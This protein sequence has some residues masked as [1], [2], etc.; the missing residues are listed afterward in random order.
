LGALL[1]D[2]V[3]TEEEPEPIPDRRWGR[4]GGWRGWE[5]RALLLVADQ[6]TADETSRR[7]TSRRLA[8]AIAEAVPTRDR[9]GGP[10]EI[11]P[12]HPDQLER[13]RPLDE[14]TNRP[15]A[16]GAG[17]ILLA[18]GGVLLALALIKPPAD[19]RPRAA[20][21]GPDAAGDVRVAAPAPGSVLEADGKRY[22]VGQQ[23]DHLLVGDW[24]CDG[25]PTPAAFRPS[26]REVFVFDRWARTGEIAVHAIATVPEGVAM[27]SQASS[28]GCP[29]LSVR[30]AGG[31][32]VSVDLGA[33]R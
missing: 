33:L 19:Q 20:T 7:P 2:L 18:V 26:T 1:A 16:R 21:G 29:D 13:P 10:D 31:S 17:V 24:S 4:R 3:G 9:A 32:L 25:S 8:A 14:P 28:M 27:Q 11:E 15:R 22:L 6:A 12:R 5:R 23:G 30:T